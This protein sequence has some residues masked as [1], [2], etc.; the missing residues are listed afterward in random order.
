MIV[1]L[2]I[3]IKGRNYN[4]NNNNDDVNNNNDD[5]KYSNVVNSKY[6]D[7]WFLGKDGIDSIPD[8]IV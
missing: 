1:N 4:N 2:I 8:G 6:Y 3:L 5:N 7:V